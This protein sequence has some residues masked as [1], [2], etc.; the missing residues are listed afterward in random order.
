[1]KMYNTDKILVTKMEAPEK[2]AKVQEIC[3][4]KTATIT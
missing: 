1:M 3:T 4:G 2:I